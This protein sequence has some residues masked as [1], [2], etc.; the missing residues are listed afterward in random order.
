MRR[1]DN[2]KRFGNRN[3]CLS[4]EAKFWRKE[5]YRLNKTKASSTH[6]KRI[7]GY[8]WKF[9]HAPDSFGDNWTRSRSVA[10]RVQRLGQAGSRQA[11]QSL[12]RQTT[13]LYVVHS[14]LSNNA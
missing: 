2:Q 8:A 6:S 9:E 10:D 11:I 14:F 3:G 7:T 13:Y 12:R 4:A 5:M 1:K